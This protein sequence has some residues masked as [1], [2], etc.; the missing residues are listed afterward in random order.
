VKKA[1]YGGFSKDTKPLAPIVPMMTVVQDRVAVEIARG[2]TNGCRFCQAGIIYRPVRERGVNEICNFARDAIEKTGYREVSLLSLDTGD[3]SQIDPLLHNLSSE[4]TRKHVSV[5]LPSLRAETVTPSMLEEISAV[6]SSGF[7]IAPEA[8]TQRLRDIINKNLT[9]DDIINAA[10]Y[11]KNAGFN[12][13][14]LYFMCGLPFETDEDLIEISNLVQRI[15]RAMPKGKGYFDITVSVSNFVPKPFTPFE[16][17]GQD[18]RENLLRKQRLLI[19]SLK[20]AKIKLK[21]HNV[22]VSMLEAALSRGGSIWREVFSETVKEDFYLDAWSEYFSMER[23]DNIFVKL[24]VNPDKIATACYNEEEELPWG[25]IDVGV[26]K[27]WLNHQAKLAEIGEKTLD[28]RQ[29]DCTACGACD[30]KNLEYVR[31]AEVPKS[32]KDVANKETRFVRYELKYS[33]SG[34]AALLSALDTTKLFS[35]AFG[36]CRVN[37][38]Y[39]N[40][41]NPAP[42]IVLRTPL[43]V[44]VSGLAESLMFEAETVGDL[45]N[46]VCTL[47]KFMPEGLIVTSISTA[48]WPQSQSKYRAKYKFDGES[49]NFLMECLKKDK[50]SYLRADKLVMLSDYML[51]VFSDGIAVKITEKGGFHFPM[52]FRS[53]GFNRAPVIIRSE[54]EAE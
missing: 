24:G 19:E 16:R 47:N 51:F 34:I 23:W 44:G 53:A 41:F 9:E 2:C 37:L 39:T 35:H 48:T 20:Q 28:C 5:S 3:F 7:T 1:I 38:K 17:F 52:F 4:F 22:Y 21:L 27:G 54:L 14:K 25:N 46:L 40:G 6:R 36:S 33:R 26:S 30:F 31:A 49:F 10:I 45:D 18:S 12:G 8:A 50:A 15:K 32:N 11:A 42:R 13:V 29:G 43:P